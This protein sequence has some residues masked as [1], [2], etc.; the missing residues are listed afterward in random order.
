MRGPARLSDET[1]EILLLLL[2]PHAQLPCIKNGLRGSSQFGHHHQMD[3]RK[4][5][6]ISRHAFR[7]GIFSVLPLL[8]GIVAFGMSYGAVAAKAGVSLLDTCL[9]SALVFAGASQF[10]A[11][12]AW[13]SQWSLA[14][15]VTICLLVGIVN[16]RLILMGAALRPYFAKA[17]P[18]QAY[19]LLALNTDASWIMM[20]RLEGKTEEGDVGAF[21][22]AS[23]MLW[24]VWQASTIPGW[25]LG[26]LAGDPKRLALDLVMIVF[27]ACFLVP[28]WKGTRNALPWVV[29]LV[30][31]LVTQALL[32][33]QTY[34]L[35]GALSGALA[36]AFIDE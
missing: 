32:P 11:V 18:S 2:E 8:P 28:M 21:L 13:Q 36:G 29:A 22:G 33:G 27:F 16:S 1:V 20:M 15:V 7:L 31:A 6:I 24:L 4:S 17:P 10:V 14:A 19:G 12:S 9:M 23:L 25:W 30:V 35:T 5:L 34:I 3:N 26:A